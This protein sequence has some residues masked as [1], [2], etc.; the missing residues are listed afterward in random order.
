MTEAVVIAQII[1]NII[2]IVVCVRLCIL[3]LNE[4]KENK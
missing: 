4:D 3:I 2:T 1:G